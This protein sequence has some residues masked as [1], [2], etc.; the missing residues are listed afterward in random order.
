VSNDVLN[1]VLD[2]ARRFEA[3]H[4]RPWR[5]A[6]GTRIDL[7]CHSTFSDERIKWVPGIL[8]HPV[9]TPG[10]VYDLAKSRGMDFVTITD[11]DSIDGCLHLL[12][13]RGPLDDFI[14][15][16]EVSVRFPDDGTI[17]HVNVF[18]HDEA[19]HRELQRVRHDLFDF[20]AY[21]RSIDKLFV[22]NHMTWTAQH[23]V[24]TPAQITTLLEHFPVFEGLNG[25]R[26]YAHN[27]YAWY[28]TRGHDKVLVAGSDSH[29]TRVGTTYTRTEGATRAE[30][31]A[32][33]R[34]GTATMH[35]GFGTPEKLADDVVQVIQAEVDRRVEEATHLW[36]RVVARGAQRLARRTYPL[37]CRGYH[38]RQNA[39][40]R[41]FAQALPTL[42]PPTPPLMRV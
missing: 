14:I 21:V 28:A 1:P 32:N 17:I 42:E 13:E 4:V 40:I 2:F 35:G 20:V 37:I 15:G 8:Y 11:H 9:L 7:H 10:E 39:L 36:Q 34:A 18:D 23:R 31:L 29:T 26:S 3:D 25:T 16:E 6:A 30:V 24:L 12:N 22:L 33:I 38:K 19:Q 41:A 5:Q 27:A